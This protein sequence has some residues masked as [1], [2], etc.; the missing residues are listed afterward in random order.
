MDWQ[1]EIE[2]MSAEG[3]AAACVPAALKEAGLPV[4]DDLF[5]KAAFSG[6]MDPIQEAEQLGYKAEI[7]DM[8]IDELTTNLSNL[9]RQ[10]KAVLIRIGVPSEIGVIPQHINAVKTVSQINGKPAL[11]L[12]GVPPFGKKAG[13]VFETSVLEKVLPKEG[14][15][16]L[17]KSQTD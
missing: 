13:N 16:L 4:P 5:I 6:G 8:S 2:E 12:G 17:S 15:I 14:I 9:Q 11:G 10:G 3:Q 7:T 1:R